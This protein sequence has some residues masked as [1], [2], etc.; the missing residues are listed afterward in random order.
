M[1]DLFQQGICLERR[2][3]ASL[4]EQACAAKAGRSPPLYR[5]QAGVEE[6][7][8]ILAG[9]NVECDAHAEYPGEFATV[10]ESIL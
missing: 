2:A 4:G 6:E 7:G 3:E 9:Y 10:V 5:D 8:Q 1:F